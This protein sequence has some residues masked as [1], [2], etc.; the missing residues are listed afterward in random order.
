MYPFVR[1]AKVLWQ[2]RRRPALPI[3]GE[4]RITLRCW[5]IDIDMFGEMNNGRVSTLYDLGRFDLA[6]RCGL[7]DVLRRR[8]WALAVAGSSLRFRRRVHAF[9]TV[10]IRSRLLGFED[11]WAYIAQS[12][13][14]DGTACSSI[15]LRTA[16]TG[17]DGAVPSPDV[18][19][20]L[21]HP[22]ESPALPD[23]ARAWIEADRFR[24]WPPE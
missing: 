5:P 23:W 18:L 14:R 10:E 17:P 12:M 20:E 24:P 16:V 13:W 1:F 8:K 9:Q 22:G 4:S 11:R 2:A 6:Q 3:T 15:L 7:I 19:A 21:G